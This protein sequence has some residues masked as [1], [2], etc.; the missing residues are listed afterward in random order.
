MVASFLDLPAEL[1]LMIKNAIPASDLR[2][3]V[4]FYLSSPHCAILYDSDPDPDDFWMRACWSC[5]IG[6][7]DVEF[8]MQRSWRDIAFECIQADG[9][10]THPQCG[11]SLLEYNRQ[12]LPS[13]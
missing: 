2:T 11:E 13:S 6:A 4:C 9:F 7:L 3:H 1:G 10:C 12:S 8:I 5:G